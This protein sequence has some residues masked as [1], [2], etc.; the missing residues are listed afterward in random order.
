MATGASHLECSEIYG[1]PKAFSEVETI[2]LGNY[3]WNNRNTI[4]LY[5][6]L[7]GY[8]SYILYPWAF[9]T[10]VAKNQ[11]ELHTLGLE[12]NSAISR[13]Y[14]TRYQVGAPPRILYAVA[15]GSADYAKGVAGIDLAYTIELPAGGPYNFDPPPS[16]IRPT[17]QETWEG[18]KVFHRHIERKHGKG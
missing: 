3:L 13:V 4:K 6:S 2:I 10:A 15:G 12:V 7:H 14:G 1:G 5:V 9:T 18:F 16:K 17:V 11:N 8:G